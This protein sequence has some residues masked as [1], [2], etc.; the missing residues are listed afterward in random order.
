V[1]IGFRIERRVGLGGPLRQACNKRIT[2]AQEAV[3]LP[4]GLVIFVALWAVPLLDRD[5]PNVPYS[6]YVQATKP[7][8]SNDPSECIAVG[9]GGA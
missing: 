9:G 5:R 7:A 1:P 3:G 8:A 6:L 4:L 2:W